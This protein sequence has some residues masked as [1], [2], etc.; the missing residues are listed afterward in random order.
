TN[1]KITTPEDLSLAETIARGGRLVGT[2]RAGIGY[3]LHRLVEGRALVLGGVMVPSARGA[4]G[5]SDADVVCHAITDAILGAACLGDIGRHFP[6]SDARWKNASSLDLLRRAVAIIAEQR[7]EVG[8]V[9]VTV[10][11]ERPK[12]KDY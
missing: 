11:L 4:L 8:N 1:I 3:D 12:L 6:D 9:D 2:G 5:H 10:L 7:F